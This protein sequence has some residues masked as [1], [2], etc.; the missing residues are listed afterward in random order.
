MSK[1]KEKPVRVPEK[2]Q[3]VPLVYGSVLLF[4][5]IISLT[6][7]NLIYSGVNFADTLHIL[8]WTVT[9]VPIAIALMIA[10]YRMMRY[11]SERL[12]LRIDIFAL[13][14]LVILIY[15]GLMPLWVKIMSPTAYALEMVCFASVWVFYV[16]SVQSFI[17]SEHKRLNKRNLCG[18]TDTKPE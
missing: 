6:W 4:L 3:P 9:G 8:K 16:L 11:G 14:W 2:Y 17:P 7:P 1:P 10:G 18:V 15:C 5:W 13:I 12:K